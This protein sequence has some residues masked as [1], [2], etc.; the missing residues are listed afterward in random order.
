[1]GMMLMDILQS[2]LILIISTTI[3]MHGG[4][5]DWSVNVIFLIAMDVNWFTGCENKHDQH[6]A[7]SG[8]FMVG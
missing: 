7:F 6:D 3:I 4:A 8:W 2:I 5:A 1:M